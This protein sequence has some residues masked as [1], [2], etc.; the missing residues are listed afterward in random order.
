MNLLDGLKSLAPNLIGSLGGVP[1]LALSAVSFIANKFGWDASSV[2]DIKKNLSN[3]TPEQVLSLKSLD[4]EFAKIE[5]QN[6][7]MIDSTDKAQI[8]LNTQELAKNF[9]NSGWRPIAGWVCVLSIFIDTPLRLILSIFN[10][11][12]A[13]VDLSSVIQILVGILGVGAMRT[14]EKIKGV[15]TK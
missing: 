4:L 13:H 12:M 5:S 3:M 9:L 6:L 10:I 8:Q 14:Y 15:A 2:D 1:S 7:V 11:G